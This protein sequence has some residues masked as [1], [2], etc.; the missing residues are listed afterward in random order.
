M[1]I[2]QEKTPFYIRTTEGECFYTDTLDEALKHFASEEGYRLTITA[3]E[4]EVVI[5]RDTN[6]T[7]T[8]FDLKETEKMYVA[9]IT[10]RTVA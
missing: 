8:T 7:I 2:T 1:A 4:H 10:I 3:G 6:A 9:N 5:R